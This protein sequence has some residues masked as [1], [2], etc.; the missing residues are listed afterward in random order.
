MPSVTSLIFPEQ[1][2][3][4]GDDMQRLIATNRVVVDESLD[5][6]GKPPSRSA[7]SPSPP[8]RARG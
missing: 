6:I 8:S 4:T 5:N 7:T 2:K 1:L 3:A